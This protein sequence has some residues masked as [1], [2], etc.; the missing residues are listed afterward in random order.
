MRDKVKQNLCG[1][2]GSVPLRR[3]FGSEGAKCRSGDEM[4]LVVEVV[5]DD[6]MDAKEALGG[7][8]GLE[9]LHLALASSHGLMGVLGTIVRP[10]PLL[11]WAG[12]A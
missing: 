10:Q 7:S 2:D 8:G 3:R 12:Q 9:T 4:A 1:G 11:M 5:V 6:S